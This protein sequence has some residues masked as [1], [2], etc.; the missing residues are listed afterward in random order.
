MELSFVGLLA[1][2]FT[3]I[4]AASTPLKTGTLDDERGINSNNALINDSVVVED[5]NHGNIILFLQYHLLLIDY[6]FYYP[7]KN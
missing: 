4:N 6:N 5:R 3:I 7:M 1:S 2:C